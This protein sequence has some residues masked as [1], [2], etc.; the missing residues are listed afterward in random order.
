MK[1]LLPTIVLCSSL[2]RAATM[3]PLSEVEEWRAADGVCRGRVASVKCQTDPAT[4]QVFTRAV[5]AVEEGFRGRLPARVAVNYPGGSLDGRG[6]DRGDSPAL[7]T[8]EERLFFLHRKA[9]DDALRLVNGH[10]GAKRLARRTDGELTLDEALRQRRYRRWAAEPGGEGADL[11]SLEAPPPAVGHDIAANGTPGNIT[12]SGLVVSSNGVPARWLAPDRGEPIPYLVDA[13][14]MPAGV[15]QEQAL[16]AVQN[17][18]A[19]WTTVTGMTFRF[20]GLQDFQMAATNV[21]TEDE[22]LR[23]QLHDTY[24]A[25]TSLAT[26]GLGGRAWNSTDGS[27]DITGGGGGQVNGLEFHKAVRGYVVVRH[28]APALS[29]LKTL[30]ETLC[31]EFGHAFGLAHS[32][33]DPSE[34]I[35]LLKEAMMYF[36]VHQD[37]RGATIGAYDSPLIQKA[38]PPGN[39]PPWTSP[40][41]MT[42]HTGNSAQT[43]PGVNELTLTAFDRQTSSLALTLVPGVTSGTQGTFSFPG[44]TRVRFTPAASYSDAAIVNPG[45]GAFYTK[46]LYRFGD[47]VNCSPWQPVSV[48]VWRRDTSP[49]N[50]DGMPDSWM[51]THFGSKDAA[52][53]PNRGPAQDYDNDGLTNLEEYRLGTSPVSGASRFDLTALPGD[54]I[55]WPA[56]PW[57]LYQLESSTDA[58]NWQ[59]AQS[60]IPPHVTGF[61]T[62][63]VT[64]S[65]TA[66]RDPLQGRRLLRLRQIQ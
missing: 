9:A 65:T 26:L 3:L 47:G 37:D 58:V 21:L 24:G 59:W 40:R 35:V 33:E 12:A 61:P 43:A 30:E 51:V 44:G 54:V 16:T 48:I 27:L 15:T 56:K 50:G 1:L 6:D 7:K 64:A 66:P 57:A 22:K 10:A 17:A 2:A 4:G 28:D 45:S 49:A 55:Q 62:T 63:T 41:Y 20:E 32:S 38:Q 14:V 5:I 23:I 8:G 52:L 11:S 18:L 39:T 53:G 34:P 60:I 36:R 31:H 19:A 13:T 46:L 42:A 25:I 29:N